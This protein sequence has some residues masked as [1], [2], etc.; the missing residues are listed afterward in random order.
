VILFLV[1]RWA[2]HRAGLLARPG[3][4][5]GLLRSQGCGLCRILVET[6]R[7]PDFYM[8]AFPLEL[9][10]GMILSLPMV[11]FGA[12]LIRRGLAARLDPGAR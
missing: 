9:T 8:P 4:T 11:A 2:T 10:M 1:L 6:V 3:V 7:E 5:A 12:W